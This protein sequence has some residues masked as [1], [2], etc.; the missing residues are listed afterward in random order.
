MRAIDTHSIQ[1]NSIYSLESKLQGR[2]APATIDMTSSLGN[3]SGELKLSN[4]AIHPSWGSFLRPCY[5][6]CVQPPVRNNQ[7][8]LG[9][10]HT[11]SHSSGDPG[12][13]IGGEENC[14]QGV[15][16]C[17]VGRHNKVLHSARWTFPVSSIKMPL[18]GGVTALPPCGI[19]DPHTYL[20]A[21][22]GVRCP[23]GCYYCHWRVPQGKG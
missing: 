4:N 8:Y 5:L 12:A 21:V 19:A 15:L 10:A 18:S 13:A 20:S 2:F 17:H 11:L 7:T 16:L 1:F 3:G 14:Q 6:F 22:G 9:C 23:I